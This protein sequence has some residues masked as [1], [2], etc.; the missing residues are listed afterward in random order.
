[1][2]QSDTNML[3]LIGTLS[4]VR[5]NFYSKLFVHFSWILKGHLIRNFLTQ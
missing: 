3:V 2:T 5:V 4:C 1:M